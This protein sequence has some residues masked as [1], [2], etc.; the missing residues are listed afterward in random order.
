M[1]DLILKYA[2]QN[3]VRYNGKA[4]LNAV[5]SKIFSGQDIKDK[6][7]LIDQVKEIVKEVNRLTLNEQKTKLEDIAPELLEVKK[8]KQE[9]TLP[10]LKNAKGK[11]VLRFAPYPS[12]PLHIGNAR[13]AILNDFY[14]K[15]Y[16]GK[17]FLVMDDT[18]GSEEKNIL[19][20][21]YKLIPEGLRYLN[22]N[23]DNVYFKS[24]R[25]HIYY[26]H[27]REL[28]KKHKAYVCKCSSEKLREF[29]KNGFP[30]LHRDYSIEENLSLFKEM[31][32]AKEGS[33]IL[34]IKTDMSDKNP[35]FRD[36]VIMRISDRKHPRTKNE[37]RIWPLLDFSWAIDDHLLG[38]THIIRGKELM[39]ESQMEK[40][41]WDI[42]GWPQREII[43]TGLLQLEG[44]KI[45]K[46][47]SKQEVLSGKYFGW[48]DPRTFSLQ[49]LE[50]RGFKQEAIRN[51]L[52]KFGLNQTEIT[53]PIEDLYT[54]NRKLIESQSNRYFFIEKSKA[55]KV[56]IK[57]ASKLTAKLP[58]HPDF[59]RGFREIKTSNEFYIQDKLEKNKCYRLM[60]LFNIKNNQFISEK[61]DQGLNAK[62]IHWLP[63]NGIINVE[64]V[65][66]TG[67]I[68]KGYGELDLKNLKVNEVIQFTRLFFCKLDK[69]END[70]LVFWYLHK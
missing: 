57:N 27:A 33:M 30:C 5:I 26:E 38:I 42:F 8:E 64:V 66:D 7:K 69:K 14:A 39:I 63:T 3:A 50:R 23:F 20:E 1:K 41:I 37:Y 11:V 54:E 47:K 24:D 28:I 70:K 18:I 19:K 21:A 16:H 53:V 43:H 65:M 4:E 56:K 25:L 55:K 31:F 62:L 34:R 6:K 36:R 10:D 45:S 49:S 48:D 17:L 15:K 40:Y 22:I 12:G 46:S 59:N 61:P 44:F 60:N 29:R 58:L 2:L 35:A 9:L 67:E 51:F 68:I 32:T 52:L 13:P